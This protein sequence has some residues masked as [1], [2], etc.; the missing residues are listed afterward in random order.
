MWKEEG[1]GAEQPKTRSA[2]HHRDAN[3]ERFF[4]TIVVHFIL[5]CAP[6]SLEKRR[7]FQAIDEVESRAQANRALRLRFSQGNSCRLQ[8]AFKNSVFEAS[9]VVSTKTLSLKHYHR[10]QG[11]WPLSVRCQLLLDRVCHAR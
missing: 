4:W 8:K 11:W 5:V 10:R 9:K 7:G 1:S 3:V 2:R 6:V